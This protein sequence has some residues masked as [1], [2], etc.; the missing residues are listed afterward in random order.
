VQ[1]R[2]EDPLVVHMHARLRACHSLDLLA[3]ARVLTWLQL[4]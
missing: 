1:R 3:F 4:K 2:E